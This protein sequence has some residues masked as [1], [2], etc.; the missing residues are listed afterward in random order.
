MIALWHI[1]ILH[2]YI[3]NIRKYYIYIY[4][5]R[6]CSHRTRAAVLAAVVSCPGEYIAL[7]WYIFVSNMY[8]SKHIYIILI[9]YSIY[10]YVISLHEHVLP[11]NWGWR[12]CGNQHPAAMVYIIYILCI[13]YHGEYTRETLLLPCSEQKLQ[14][15][16][17]RSLAISSA[18]T[19][20]PRHIC[21]VN[22][23]IFARESVYICA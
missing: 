8:N 7:P 16:R 1:Y 9:C 6:P 21:Q 18:R 4:E 10:I 2:K 12:P 14:K 22:H 15:G 11:C 17:T 13:I 20:L 5:Y 19:A 23:E 3:Y